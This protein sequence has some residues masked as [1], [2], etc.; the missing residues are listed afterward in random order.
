MD[1]T[2][3]DNFIFQGEIARYRL[4]LLCNGFE[5]PFG[6]ALETK[7]LSLLLVLVTKFVES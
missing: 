5:D 6:L 7:V 1:I 2:L 4:L 3:D